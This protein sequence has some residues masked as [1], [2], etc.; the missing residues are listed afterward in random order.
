MSLELI[1]PMLGV[2]GLAIAFVI[3]AWIAKQKVTNEKVEKIGRQIHIGAMAF[4]RQE[5]RIMLIF[6]VVLAAAIAFSDLGVQYHDCLYSWRGMF[7][8]CWLH[9]YVYGN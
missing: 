8:G 7:C 5:Y 4:M 9:W 2:F 1:P 6:I 3:Y